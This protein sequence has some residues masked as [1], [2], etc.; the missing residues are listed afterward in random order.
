MSP[1]IAEAVERLKLIG[2]DQ[3][4]ADLFSSY[5]DQSLQ[6]ITAIQTALQAG[7]MKTVGAA[8]H[9]LKGSSGAIGAVYLA[10]LCSSVDEAVRTGETGDIERLVMNLVS[11][12][13]IVRASAAQFAAPK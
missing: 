6:N 5:L 2:G 11:E 1:E 8:A 3:F 10:E 13:R 12:Y 7:D 9:T 4:V